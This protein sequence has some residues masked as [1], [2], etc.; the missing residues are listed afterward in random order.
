M[1]DLLA[2]A[3]LLLTVATVLDALW[4]PEIV[5]S[6]DLPVSEHKP[7]NRPNYERCRSVFWLKTVPL[8]I[9]TGILC[10][11]NLPDTYGIVREA[12]HH[13]GAVGTAAIRDYSA[14]KTSY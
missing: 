5:T 3:T 2:A 8:S 1:G 10:V 4:Y 9:I 13:A 7:D 6:L 12:I 11:L 14:I